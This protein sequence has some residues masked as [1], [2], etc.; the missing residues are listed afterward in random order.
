MRFKA[1]KTTNEFI[2]IPILFDYVE[3]GNCDGC[4]W[5]GLRHQRCSCCRRNR[6]L[7][8][9]YTNKEEG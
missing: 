5:K 9:G 3:I 2:L 1:A 4:V 8:D 7:K 6:F